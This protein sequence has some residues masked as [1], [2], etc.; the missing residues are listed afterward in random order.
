MRTQQIFTNMCVSSSSLE[1][2]PLYGNMDVSL[3]IY[4][5]NKSYSVSET[6]SV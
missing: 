3:E 4:Q 5:S 1:H 6:N 2:Q